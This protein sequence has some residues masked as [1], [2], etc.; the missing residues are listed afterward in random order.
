MTHDNSP[1]LV[2]VQLGVNPSPILLHSADAAIDQLGGAKAVLI[3]DLPS[4]W[5]KFPGLV[6]EYNVQKDR[7]LSIQKLVKRF[8]ERD[9]ISGS[10]WIFTLERLFAL[11]I[12]CKH[13]S[14]NTAVLHIES[15]NYSL[16][17]QTIFDEMIARCLKVAAPRFSDSQGIASILFAPTLAD[18]KQTIQKFSEYIDH[19]KSWLGDMNLLGLA[20]NDGVIHELPTKLNDAWTI[21]PTILNNKKEKLIFDGLA[22]GQYLYGQDPYHTNGYA[23]P[24][25]VNEN[26]SEQITEWKWFI[27]EGFGGSHSNLNF[28][29]KSTNF[30]VANIHVHS[31]IFLPKLEISDDTW[32][33]TIEIANG[34]KNPIARKMPLYEIHT[35][36][37]SFR[38]KFRFAR[39]NGWLHL[40][41]EATYR[42]RRLV[43]KT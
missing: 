21:G 43:S 26:F 2:F 29:F 15:D 8:P 6:I 40:L 37:I 9:E 34:L 16:I 41:R 18:L 11:E 35:V 4:E 17:D 31:K 7:H 20:L 32:I 36:N 24:G 38:N 12:L 5:T 42:I 33:E 28:E 30:R 10:Y 19:S 25:H 14:E 22:I 23:I 27:D 1:L 13:F 3:T 39:R